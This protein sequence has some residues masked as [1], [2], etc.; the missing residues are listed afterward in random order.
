[1]SGVAG[2]PVIDSPQASMRSG[3]SPKATPARTALRSRFAIVSRTIAP[4]FALASLIATHVP[5]AATCSFGQACAVGAGSPA[6]APSIA[7]P[8]TPTKPANTNPSV[9][10]ETSFRMAVL[11]SLKARRLDSKAAIVVGFANAY[12]R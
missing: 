9:V 10:A 3:L 1:M 11:F 4:I 8:A 2:T 6:R 5:A 7:K 12:A